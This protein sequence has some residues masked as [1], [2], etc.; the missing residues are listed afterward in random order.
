[1]SHERFSER[2]LDLAYGELSPREAGKVEAHAASCAECGAELA[3]IRATRRLMAALPDERAPDRGERVL[4]A[5]AREEVRG[6]APVRS[7][8]RWMW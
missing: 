3:R 1:M 8:S 6:R 2:I 4:L 7:W 5:A